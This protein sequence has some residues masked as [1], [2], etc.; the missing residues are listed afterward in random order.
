MKGA[1]RLGSPFGIGVFVHWTFTFLLAYVAYLSFQTGQGV[2]A[3]VFGI[4]FVLSVFACVVLHELGH[5]LMARRFGIPTKDITLFPIGGIARLAKMPEK[6]SSE[7][8]VAIAGPAV[9]VAIAA[10]I[11]AMMLLFGAYNAETLNKTFVG[12]LYKVNI[13]L[14]LFNLLPAFPMDGGRALRALLAM[15]MDRG[16]ATQIAAAIGQAM[17]MVFA[18]LG[19]FVFENLIWV[20]IGVFVFFGA[21]AE[22][23]MTQADSVLG[24]LKVRDGMVIRFV[25]LNANDAID[26]AVQE[27]LAGSQIDFPVVQDGDY[28]GILERNGIVR[29]LSEDGK[30]R[31]VKDSVVRGAPI[32]RPDDSLTEAFETMRVGGLST[33]PVLEGKRVVGLL[34]LDNIAELIH[35]RSAMRRV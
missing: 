4:L 14:V 34:T 12:W 6:P 15:R 21:G 18:L 13:F 20:L 2:G 19:F 35:V 5:A 31:E 9:N 25:T 1:L 24:S 30:N 10:G 8:L 7:M 16:K 26:R 11:A 22:L 27:L 29:A 28:L 33:C 3:A 32:L 17:A 23:R